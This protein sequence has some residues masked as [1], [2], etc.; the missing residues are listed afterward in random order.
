MNFWGWLL[1]EAGGLIERFWQAWGLVFALALLALA[2]WA[3]RRALRLSRTAGRGEN[4]GDLTRWLFACLAV[5][6]FLVLV[7]TMMF[8]DASPIFEHRILAPLYLPLLVLFF[9]LLAWLLPRRG[10]AT[11]VAVAVLV[12]GLLLSFAEDA[13]DGFALY[14]EG[15]QGFASPTW[16]ASRTLAETK[17]LPD[18]T[19]YT[20]RQS[21]VYL[22]ADRPAYILPSPIN[23]A[24]LLPR[25]GYAEDLAN[26]RQSVL[27]G[28]GV[29]VI[30]QYDQIIQEPQDRAWLDEVSAGLPVYSRA[31]DGIIWGDPN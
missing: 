22:L 23:P 25:E 15:G 10:W 26:I 31:E 4:D 19:I 3:V 12:I 7:L 5:V 14:R 28:R 16:T 30:F 2:L 1:P 21:V 13:V 11:R 24:T 6:Y 20:N 27:E 17:T 29:I 8:L 9:A 18:V